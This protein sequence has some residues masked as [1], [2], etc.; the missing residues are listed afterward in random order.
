EIVLSPN[1]KAG[2]SGLASE[3]ATN[4][5]HRFMARSRTLPGPSKMNSTVDPDDFA[6]DELVRFEEFNRADDLGEAPHP[7]ERGSVDVILQPICRERRARRLNVDETERERIH[8]HAHGTKF[9]R[10]RPRQSFDAGLGGAVGRLAG[11]A[12]AG[13]RTEI[14]DCAA[15]SAH[16]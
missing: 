9:D 2:A 11:V 8:P 6:V 7:A 3:T 1:S 12:A 15:A 16:H 14:D 13:D 4:A 10:H 5:F